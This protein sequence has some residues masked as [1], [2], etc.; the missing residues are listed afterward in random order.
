MRAM[1]VGGQAQ[2]RPS[3]PRAP[4]SGSYP[5]ELGCPHFLW[6]RSPSFL[7]SGQR[8]RGKSFLFPC[9]KANKQLGQG[10]QIQGTVSCVRPPP[11]QV[12]RFSI[13]TTKKRP[14]PQ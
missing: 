8:G 1:L 4:K 5:P 3:L 7:F 13:H 9:L 11:Q 6:D 10:W 14:D 2:D 12:A